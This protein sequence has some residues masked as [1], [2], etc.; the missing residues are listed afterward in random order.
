V[1]VCVWCVC[2]RDCGVC[3][4]GVCVRAGGVC[5]GYV[6]DCVGLYDSITCVERCGRNPVYLQIN[7]CNI[8]I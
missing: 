4:C 8:F 6:R 5:V 3:V 1:C 7:S 2:V